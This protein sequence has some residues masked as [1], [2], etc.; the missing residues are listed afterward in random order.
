MVLLMVARKE[1]SDTKDESHDLR[2]TM[3]IHDSRNSRAPSRM[4]GEDIFPR[5]W[6]HIEQL[7]CKGEE[8]WGATR[9]AKNVSYHFRA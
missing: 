1:R 6:E 9:V 7:C 4:A 8:T 2:M 5:E 3:T